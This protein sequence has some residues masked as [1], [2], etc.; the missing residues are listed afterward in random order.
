[1]QLESSGR[2]L[3]VSRVRIT[4][5]GVRKEKVDCVRVWDGVKKFEY[6]I[7]QEMNE[8]E[9]EGRRPDAMSIVDRVHYLKHIAKV[10]Q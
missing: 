8:A 6:M 2:D 4:G 9:Q 3:Y 5:G 7:G 10:K 1:M